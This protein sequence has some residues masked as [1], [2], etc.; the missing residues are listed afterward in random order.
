MRISVE[1]FLDQT[2]TRGTWYGGGSAAALACA[3][4]A[5]LLEKLATHAPTA[6]ASRT[7]RRQCTQLIEEDARTFANVI[8]VMVRGDRAGTKRALKAATQV[9]WR[10]WAASQ[11]LQ[12]L[13]RRIR[14]DIRPRFRVDLNCALA[15]ARASAAS[16][17]ALVETN[18]A[19]L[20][21]R[22]YTRQL[23]RRMARLAQ[24]V[25]K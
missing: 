10:V 3:L 18:L 14:R 6:R 2:D 15:L 11:R 20:N 23:R 25:K 12:P 1:Q 13:A 9:P 17:S 21:D 24:E 7:I 19:W 5:A 4:S 16:S 8:H 22:A